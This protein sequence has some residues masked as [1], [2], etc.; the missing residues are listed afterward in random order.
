[1]VETE[2][3]QE[4]E[5]MDR[6]RTFTLIELLVVIAIIAILAS[7]LLP[8][9]QNARGKALQATCQANC[10]QIALAFHM[11]SQESD[12]KLPWCCTAPPRAT[13]PGLNLHPWWRPGTNNASDVRYNGLLMP[14]LQ[15]R[16][17]W[18]CPTSGR[19]VNSYS[20]PRQL[21]Q[22]SGGCYGQPMIRIRYPSDHVLMGDGIGTRGFC[23]TN[24]ATACTG[25]WGIGVGTVAHIVA[26]QIHS[27][28][29]NLAF[30][31][32]HVRWR[33]TPMAAMDQAVCLR[34]FGNPTTP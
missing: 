16:E 24:R 31:D 20:A 15:N 8:A 25:K 17:V 29:T 5:P 3:A 27:N 1:L 14:Y 4:V 18:R 32:G 23:G 22:G 6:R 33:N 28:G 30:V 2:L 12:Q 10:K 26:Y 19:D 21:L 13:N 7:L 34:M 11:Y 9:L